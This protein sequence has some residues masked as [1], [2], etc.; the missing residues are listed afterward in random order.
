MTKFDAMKSA[1]V[2]GALVDLLRER[3]ETK[4]QDLE[5]H[6]QDH[7]AEEEVLKGCRYNG[8]YWVRPGYKPGTWRPVALQNHIVGWRAAASSE[9]S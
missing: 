9:N 7:V 3:V 6:D 4:G 5:F 8:L 2:D 1:P